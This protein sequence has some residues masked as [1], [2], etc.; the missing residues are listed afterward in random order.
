MLLGQIGEA[1][2]HMMIIGLNKK[3]PFLSEIQVENK[4]SPKIN[5][6]NIDTYTLMQQC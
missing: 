1:M 6:K 2:V 5:K 4:S 3:M